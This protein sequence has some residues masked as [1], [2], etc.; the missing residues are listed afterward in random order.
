MGLIIDPF[1]FAVAGG[2]SIATVQGGWDGGNGVTSSSVTLTGVT[3]GNALIA[4]LFTNG[5]ISGTPGDDNGNSYT[6]NYSQSDNGQWRVYSDLDVAAGDTTF[7]LTTT[8]STQHSLAFCEAENVDSYDTAT[9]VS[10]GWGGSHSIT[11]TPTNDGALLL[12]M[13]FVSAGTPAQ[14]DP[15]TGD[16]TWVT[17]DIDTSANGGSLMSQ[18]VVT[19]AATEMESLTGASNGGGK[20][21]LAAFNS[22]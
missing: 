15:A 16:G 21:I 20:Q 12:G 6:S 19:A 22:A 17:E 14:A 1:R 4:I 11:L 13:H 8:G 10:T 3:A 18:V 9:Y 7:T 5:V 2:G